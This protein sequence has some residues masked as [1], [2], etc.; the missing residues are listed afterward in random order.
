MDRPRS[1]ASSV[2]AFGCAVNPAY[3]TA[4]DY[5]IVFTGNPNLKAEESESFNVGVSWQSAGFSA[6]LDY[7]DITQDNKIDEA[8]GFTYQEECNDQASTICIRGTPLAGDVLGPL[9][10]DQ[11]D[12]RQH[13]QAVR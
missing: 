2:D 9:A 10:A 13:Q 4:T 11:R 5:N 3:C 6:S 8:I 1:R 12:V 7:W